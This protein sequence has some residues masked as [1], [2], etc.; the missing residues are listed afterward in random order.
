MRT[1]I[2]VA[3]FIALSILILFVQH[4][5]MG[6][7]KAFD[8]ALTDIHGEEFQLSDHL[9]KVVLINFFATYCGSC[10]Q[11]MLELKSVW[12][13]FSSDRFVAVSVSV[14]MYQDTENVLLDFAKEYE[15]NWTVV[16]DIVGISS[17]YSV[18]A[19]PTL[20]LVD[21]EGYVAYTHVGVTG[22][23]TLSQEIQGL[24]TTTSTPRQRT[25][26]ID[27]WRNYGMLF[28][29]GVCTAAIISALF[30]AIRHEKNRKPKTLYASENLCNS[31]IRP[32][33][34]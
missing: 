10:R 28:L 2:H 23:S 3:I 13:R 21:P 26:M 30:L 20:V 17:Q 1:R 16:Q 7:Q 19:I 15:M 12:Q 6:R 22:E 24:Q 31:R 11:E 34:A 9:G 27:F 5:V 14:D 29:V 32:L 33:E 25:D 18:G 4:P 8:F